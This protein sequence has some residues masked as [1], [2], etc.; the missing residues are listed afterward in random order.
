[1]LCVIPYKPYKLDKNLE[2]SSKQPKYIQNGDPLD[3]RKIG[4]AYENDNGR[5]ARTHMALQSC[6]G[7]RLK[8]YELFDSYLHLKGFADPSLQK[9][10]QVHH[11]NPY[12]KLGPFKTEIVHNDPVFMIIHELLTDEDIEFLI[13]WATP[14]L[15]SEREIKLQ[16]DKH[17]RKS[18]W[19]TRKTLR[20]V[21]KSVQTWMTDK[22]FAGGKYED[23]T[24][25]NFT[26][27]FPRVVDI[28]KRIEKAI[29]MN[30]SGQWSSEKLQVTSY[31]LGGLVEDHTDPYGYNEG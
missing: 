6:G 5:Y 31:G 15:S 17:Q 18:D 16:E 24:P 7:F 1:M 28:T 19:K 20:T 14:R 29:F 22:T 2:K 10:R 26:V 8:N 25:D 23:Y 4:D 21:H 9:C 13:E 11:G 27:H 30:V 3:V 12:S